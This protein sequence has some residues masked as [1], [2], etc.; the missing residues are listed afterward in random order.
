VQSHA[1]PQ[2]ALLSQGGS[3]IRAAATRVLCVLLLGLPALF[4]GCGGAP[5][6]APAPPRLVESLV[7][8]APVL[9]PARQ[10]PG[11]VRAD[12]RAELAFRV[13]GALVDLPVQEGQYVNAGQLLARID[14]RDFENAFEARRSDLTEARTLFDRVARALQ[15]GAVT[16]AERDQVRARF[17]V[18]TA[19]L[20]L[21]ENALADTELRAP[22]AGRVARRLVENFQ[23][24]QVG[25]PILILEDLARLEVRIQLPEQDVVR[26]PPDVSML[27]TEV[28]AVTFPALRGKRFA[29]TVKEVETRADARTNTYR[30]T[31]GLARP[32]A[33]NILPGMS[34]NFVPNR[35]VVPVQP[36][37]LLPIEAIQATPDGQPF[38]WVL[39]PDGHTVLSR[40]VRK[41]RLS[42]RSIEVAEGLAAGDH[43]I[44]LGGAYLAEGM[45]V[46]TRN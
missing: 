45:P 22:F 1:I 8:G 36:S 20:A 25:E 39:A 33:G 3:R 15:A 16:V 13:A 9:P 10:Y 28:G 34:A 23:N 29:V 7:L 5:D 18:A 11:E 32:E 44:T 14:P 30:V 35:E 41:G 19:E 12:Q 4:A 40:A 38:V 42:G 26:L 37:Y 6:A 24:V 27:G 31:L 21:A 43:V 17:E 2:S 46:R